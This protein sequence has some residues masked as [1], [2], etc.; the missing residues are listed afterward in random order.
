MNTAN[1]T[2]IESSEKWWISSFWTLQN[3]EHPRILF[4]LC[5]FIYA[6]GIGCGIVS[7]RTL[8]LEFA[9]LF[10]LVLI[11]LGWWKQWYIAILTILVSLNG[12]YLGYQD[13]IWR[14]AAWRSIQAQTSGFSGSY[15]ITG[16]VDQLMYT[17]DLS[18]TY[19]LQIANIANRS[20]GHTGSLEDSDVGIFLEIPSNLHIGIN[21]M[22]EY[23]GKIMKVVDRPL[24]WFSG[25]AWYHRIYGK[26]TVPIFK[27]INRGEIG[28]LGAVQKWAKSV[29]FR[30][31]PENIAGIVL[32]MTIGNIE[33]LSS[34]T[35]KAFTNAGITHILVV[36][37]SNIAFV[38]VIL[39]GIL[40]YIPMRR[41]IRGSIVILFVLVYGS[42]VGWDMPVVRAVA[43]WLVTYMAIEWGKR[44]SSLSVLFLVGWVILLYSPLALVYDAGFGLSFAGTLG[45]LLWHPRLVRILDN[46]YT[47][48]FLI[49]IVSVTL[50]ASAG[51]II[52]II[53]HFSTIPLF[54]LASN[55]LISGVLGWILFASVLYLLFAI[56]GWWILYI[57]GW[58]IYLP[59]AYIMWVGEFFGNGYTY[60]IDAM[61]G[62][63]LALF[64][65]GIMIVVVFYLEKRTLLQPK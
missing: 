9:L 34:E 61:W 12:W 64:L 37:G 38:I 44:A 51:S 49:D 63:P 7:D 56:I 14:E 19:R 4:F 13:N 35:K 36:S 5:F 27:R 1:Y 6:I 11:L 25:Y 65:I 28:T 45:I 15:I 31:F 47:P 17:S 26:S 41:W 22:I 20:T 24:K 62:E 53:Y 33:L 10:P 3:I 16:R 55:I 54:T 23:T 48:R 46:R 59:T 21:D 57:W 18:S 43:M 52:A 42:L 50:A 8:G 32:G 60:P 58:T 30:W 2:T 39:T 29:I 40:R